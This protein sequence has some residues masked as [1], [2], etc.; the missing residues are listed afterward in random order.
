MKKVIRAGL[1]AAA[2]WL[3]AHG[4]QACI[5]F[6]PDTGY[7][8]A[9]DTLVNLPP[10]IVNQPYETVVQF[11]VPKTVLN[12]GNPINV[13]QVALTGVLGLQDIPSSVPFSYACHPESCLFPADS[14]GCVKL[15][16]TPTTEGVYPLIIQANVYLTPV[17][18]LPSPT[19]GYR[20]VVEQDVGAPLL[21]DNE[22]LLIW[23]NPA[24]TESYV[25]FTDAGS[26]QAVII[27]HDIQGK[28]I[29][30]VMMLPNSATRLDASAWPPGLYVVKVRTSSGQWIRQLVKM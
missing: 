24:A 20:I 8:I 1:L 4:Q 2:L 5:P 27:I 15:T 18:Y 25:K 12:N 23:P 3:P 21:Q 19:P 28:E 10:A 7:G 22:P 9:P 29:N 11:K 30:K 16:G 6:W 26:E 14:V 17:L 13:Y